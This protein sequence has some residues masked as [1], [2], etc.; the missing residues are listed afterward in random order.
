MI[1]YLNERPVDCACASS[2]TVEAVAQR[3]R[4]LLVAPAL[5]CGHGEHAWKA[6]SLPLSL[7]L[8]LSLSLRRKK[9][10]ETIKTIGMYA[11]QLHSHCNWFCLGLFRRPRRYSALNIYSQTLSVKSYP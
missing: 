10:G 6:L 9:K 3:R 1:S 4:S 8:S 11:M 7:S 5:R 2:F